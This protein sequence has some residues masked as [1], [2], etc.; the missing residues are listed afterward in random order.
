MIETSNMTFFYG[1][2]EILKELNFKA[3]DG[4]I[5]YLAGINGSGKT[6]W[7]K[8][9]VG[10]LKPQNGEVTFD[11]KKFENVRDEFAIC[12][13][14]PP[15]YKHL[16]C[17]ENLYVLYNVDCSKT[18]TL[19]LLQRIGLSEHLLESAAGKLSFGQRHRLGIAGALLRSPKYLILDEPDLGLDPV[20]WEAVR[21]EIF[22][23]KEKGATILL[24]GQNF[25]QLE[26]LVDHVSILSNHR[27]IEDISVDAFIEKYC[28]NGENM[29]L[30]QA[31][32]TAVR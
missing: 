10:L 6:T 9:A 4:E 14:T 30:K 32:L 24:T 7:I 11:G 25:V 29:S 26:E 31:F 3:K 8:C 12:F 18:H 28:K 2:N 20:A 5:T 22:A 23:L 19:E 15:I 17:Y 1:K 16:S 13:D 27:I 21:G